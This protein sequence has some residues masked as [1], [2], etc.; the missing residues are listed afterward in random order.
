MIGQFPAPE[1]Y[2]TKD[3]SRIRE[4]VHPL[5]SPGL[6]MSLAEAVVEAGGRT[7]AHFHT[8]FD[9]IYYC[10]EGAGVL[11]VNGQTRPFSPGAY[12]LM[13]KG[14]THFLTATTTL[15]LL[16]VCCPAYTH[17]ETIVL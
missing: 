7:E 14:S 8:T 1:P 16:C 15:R 4:L 12:H 6:G 5:L 10:L 9:E 11:H 17:E 13:P 2:V 3:G